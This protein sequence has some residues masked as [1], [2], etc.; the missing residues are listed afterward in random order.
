M[1]LANRALGARP[2]GRIRGQPRADLAGV[3]LEARD[4]RLRF[5]GQIRLNREPVRFAMPREHRRRRG[6]QL[7]RLRFEIGARA[8]PMFRRIARSL[9]AID[10]EHLATD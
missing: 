3:L 8:T 4:A 5:G 10:R 9:H 1:A 6:F 7:V 2:I